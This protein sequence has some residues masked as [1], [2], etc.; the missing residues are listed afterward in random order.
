MHLTA[1][2]DAVWGMAF[3]AQAGQT[4]DKVFNPGTEQY[5]W[6]AVY[7]GPP[8]QTAFGM[9]NTG[10][11]TLSSEKILTADAVFGRRTW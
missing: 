5:D 6:T 10:S 7:S 4:P 11:S 8:P 2:V 3:S 1:A 9:G